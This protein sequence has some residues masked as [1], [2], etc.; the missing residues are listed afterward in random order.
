MGLMADLGRNGAVSW[1][2]RSFMERSRSSAA[3]SNQFSWLFLSCWKEQ[4]DLTNA[5]LC[6]LVLQQSSEGWEK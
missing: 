1:I 3:G 2:W 6:M 5:S 4:S